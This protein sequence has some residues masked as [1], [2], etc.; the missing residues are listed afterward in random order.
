MTENEKEYILYSSTGKKESN[1]DEILQKISEIFLNQYMNELK[2]SS[3]TIPTTPT[4][5]PKSTFTSPLSTINAAKESVIYKK[6]KQ[7]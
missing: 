5:K 1:K 2:E 6:Q 7:G 4:R 3:S